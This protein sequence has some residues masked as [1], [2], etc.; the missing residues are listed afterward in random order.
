MYIVCVGHL[1]QPTYAY[2]TSNRT[3][4]FFTLNSME[5]CTNHEP[6]AWR[7]TICDPCV[8]HGLIQAL[9][10]QLPLL[11]LTVDHNNSMAVAPETTLS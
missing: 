2:F 5:P 6:G 7:L 10:G 8:N 9:K 4:T 3:L 1:I 11:L